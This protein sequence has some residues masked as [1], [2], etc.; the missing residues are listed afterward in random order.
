MSVGILSSDLPVCTVNEEFRMLVLG[1]DSACRYGF[2]L[3]RRSDGS[4]GIASALDLPT[5]FGMWRHM[6]IA[7]CHNATSPEI[8]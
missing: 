7:S 8:R 3:G 5:T 1:N 6:L 2:L 4:P